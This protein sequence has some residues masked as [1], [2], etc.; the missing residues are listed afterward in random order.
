MGYALQAKFCVTSNTPLDL[1]LKGKH[2]G[3][4][5]TA[6]EIARERNKTKVVELLERFIKNQA[7]SRQELRVELGLVDVLAA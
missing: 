6:V 7:Q 2:W 1:D 3:E 4:E 5:Y